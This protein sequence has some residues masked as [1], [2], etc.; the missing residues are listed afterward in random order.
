MVDSL[1]EKRLLVYLKIFSNEDRFGIVQ[2]L[3]LKKELCAK[4]IGEKF[5]LEQSTT[6]HHLNLMLGCGLVRVKKVGRKNFYSL[7]QK[8]IEEF[9][10]LVKDLI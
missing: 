7:N 2:L 10:H 4:D 8:V 9:M 6:S 5:F 1:D 3:K